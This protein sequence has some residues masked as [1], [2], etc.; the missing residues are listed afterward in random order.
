METS[1]FELTHYNSKLNILNNL[2]DIY[3]LNEFLRCCGSSKWASDLLSYKPYSSF[4]SLIDIAERLW[5]LQTIEEWK[6]AF[7]AHPK[8]GRKLLI[9]H[10]FRNNI[11]I[12]H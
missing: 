9:S 2:P 1:D 8:I 12:I 5:W 6:T 7:K 11:R 10:L 4:Q 3:L